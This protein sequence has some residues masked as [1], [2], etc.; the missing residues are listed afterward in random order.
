MTTGAAFIVALLVVAA[1]WAGKRHERALAVA[2]IAAAQRALE[3]R[4]AR[5]REDVAGA[6]VNDLDREL[7][8]PGDNPDG[9]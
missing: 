2:K 1:F 7:R 9:Y 3:C 4:L 5:I 6:S 8:A